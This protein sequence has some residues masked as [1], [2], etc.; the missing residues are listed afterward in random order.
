QSDRMLIRVDQ[1]KGRKDRFTLLSPFML[2]ELRTYF[3]RHK[4]LTYLFESDILGK[5]YSATSVLKI[6][7]TAARKANIR[8]RVTPHML[9]HSMA[10]HLLEDSTDL[11]QIQTLLGHNSLKTTEIDTHVV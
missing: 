2:K 1:G 7:K 11:R 3:K 6:V 5:R 9:R 8:E 10:T 4:P